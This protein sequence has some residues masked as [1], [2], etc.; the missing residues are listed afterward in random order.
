[1]SE[2]L[3]EQDYLEVRLAGAIAQGRAIDIG[4]QHWITWI[5]WAPDRDLNPRYADVPDVDRWG[6]QVWHRRSDG[7]LCCG[8]ITFDTPEVRAVLAVR[9]E[10]RNV[11][12][13]ESWDPLTVRPSVLCRFP[14]ID[15]VCNDHGFITAGRWVRA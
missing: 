15:G 12:Q 5:A 3:S 11:W 7:K 4:D 6:A 9:D 10:Q 2:D 8:A 14:L 13:V 1:M